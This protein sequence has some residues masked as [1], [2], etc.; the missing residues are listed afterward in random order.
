MS[1]QEA[2]HLRSQAWQLRHLDLSMT[3]R[4]IANL[5]KKLRKVPT[6]QIVLQ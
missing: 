6:G 5:E 4:N 3:G 1:M 2:L